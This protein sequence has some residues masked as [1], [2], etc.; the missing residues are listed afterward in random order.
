MSVIAYTLVQP[1]RGKRS[2]VEIRAKTAAGI[3]ARHGAT[4]KVTR[5]IAGEH[6][7]CIGL[8]RAYADFQTAVKTLQSVGADPA[9]QDFDRERESNP[10]ADVLVSRNIARR[11]FGEGKWA[12]HPVTL[13]RRYDLLKKN[14]EG[15]LGMLSQVADL[16]GKSD[17]NVI[18]LTP[19]AADDMSTL[20]V[21]YQFTSM[22]HMGE[23]LDG[24]GT[25]DEMR[26][27][28]AKAS[29]L[30]TLRSASMMVPI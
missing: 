8:I 4:V 7:G 26:A 30:G 24:V 13:L 19:V 21:S 25:S 11:V 29:D 20:T 12:T 5:V 22:E 18:G 28:I 2:A 9:Y 3:Y 6:S 1:H 17:V 23:S 15:A 16:V 14:M 27:L 10:V